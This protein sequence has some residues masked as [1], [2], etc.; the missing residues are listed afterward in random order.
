MFL[1]D[2]LGTLQTMMLKSVT[3]HFKNT[4]FFREGC[5]IFLYPK[6]R[7]ENTSDVLIYHTEL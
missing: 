1:W 3:V 4:E 5:E 7:P 6:C 2:S